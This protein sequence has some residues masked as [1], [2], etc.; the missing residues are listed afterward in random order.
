MVFCRIV[1]VLINTHNNG[2]ILIFAG[3]GN[4]NFLRSVINMGLGFFRIFE[5]TGAFQHD[6]VP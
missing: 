1:L 5:F 4:N 3:S 6:I 2:D